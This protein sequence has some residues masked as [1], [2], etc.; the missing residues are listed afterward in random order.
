MKT[1]YETTIES[2]IST[3]HELWHAGNPK[4][5]YKNWHEATMARWAY[6][7]KEGLDILQTRVLSHFWVTNIGHFVYLDTYIKLFHLGL[8]DA[9]NICLILDKNTRIG[10]PCLLELFK[11]HITIRIVDDSQHSD[12]FRSLLF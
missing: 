4:G 5:A 1:A 2:L 7:K 11:K 6:C 10:N 3:G 12:S 8:L 9:K